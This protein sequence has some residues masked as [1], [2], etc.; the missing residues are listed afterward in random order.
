M[1]SLISNI[2]DGNTWS[3]KKRD[4]KKQK[5]RSKKLINRSYKDPL[6]AKYRFIFFIVLLNFD[7]YQKTDLLIDNQINISLQRALQ[8]SLNDYAT[9]KRNN[10][11]LELTNLLYA[12]KQS[13]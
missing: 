9:D 5:R 6:M 13:Y 3:V 12:T 11:L 4:F 8:Q 2:R 1:V 7:L 10:D